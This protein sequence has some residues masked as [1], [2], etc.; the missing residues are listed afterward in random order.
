MINI[1]YLRVL[2]FKRMNVKNSAEL[3]GCYFLA[4]HNVPRNLYFSWMPLKSLPLSLPN[5]FIP[6]SVPRYISS[7][8]ESLKCII[9]QSLSLSASIPGAAAKSMD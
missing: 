6:N 5:R 8:V 4:L 1:L 2:H 7:V 3:S 9:C